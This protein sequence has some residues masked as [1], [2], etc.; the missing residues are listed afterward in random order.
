M[1]ALEDGF[2]GYLTL[3]LIAALAHEPWRWLGLLV[4]RRLDPESEIFK[5][6]RAVSTALVAALVAR[7]VV[8]PAGA[9]EA[10]AWPVRFGAFGL[11]IACFLAMGGRLWLALTA[12][13]ALL[14]LGTLVSG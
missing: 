3:L 6:V 4:G 8:F 13:G 1:S 2:G 11:S 12:G 7:I 14:I 5:W 9:L 10:V